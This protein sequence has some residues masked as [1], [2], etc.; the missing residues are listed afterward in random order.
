MR[1]SR[2][3][4]GA[5]PSRS[6]A[7]EPAASGDPIALIGSGG[8]LAAPIGQC[9]GALVARVAG[10]AADPA[11]LHMVQV[12]QRVEPLPQ[13]GVLHRLAVRRLP[14]TLLP[15]VDPLGDAFA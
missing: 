5:P 3:R 7:A 14:A 15:A 12:A 11:P 2:C 4:N 1:W 13:L 10:M 9:V 6:V 8:H